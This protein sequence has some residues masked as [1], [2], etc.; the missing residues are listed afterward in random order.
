MVS[1]EGAKHSQQEKTASQLRHDIGGVKINTPVKSKSPSQ[2]SVC[3][4]V[5][6]RLK[7]DKVSWWC[8]LTRPVMMSERK[9][10]NSTPT[11]MMV[12]KNPCKSMVDREEWC[13][14]HNCCYIIITQL[15]WS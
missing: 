10:S 1:K 2:N 12:K 14:V 15:M 6:G 13:D 4:K 3:P 8:K 5:A 7:V 11:W 9:S